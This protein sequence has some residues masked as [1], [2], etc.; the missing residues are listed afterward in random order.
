MHDFPQGVRFHDEV[1]EFISGGEPVNICND[2]RETRSVF[3]EVIL[4]HAYYG[5]VNGFGNGGRVKGAREGQQRWN[6]FATLMRMETHHHKRNQKYE[7]LEKCMNLPKEASGG[8]GSIWMSE[9]YL[10]KNNLIGASLSK[11]FFWL[12][13]HLLDRLVD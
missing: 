8:E 5:V 2:P 7:S 10:L 4:L 13:Y 12:Y 3:M 9:T 11:A 1:G 6:M